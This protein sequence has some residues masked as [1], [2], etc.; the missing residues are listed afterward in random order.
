MG[1]LHALFLFSVGCCKDQDCFA[2]FIVGS[3]S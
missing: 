2:R 1:E 3:F